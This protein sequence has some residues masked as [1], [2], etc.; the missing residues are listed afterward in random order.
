LTKDVVKQGY[1]EAQDSLKQKQI[2]EVKRIVLKTLEKIESLK[3]ER[4]SANDR[5]K[6]ID[7][8]IKLLKLDIDDLKEGRLDLMEERQA[9]DAKAKDTSLVIIVKETKVEH[10]YPY[11]Y[12]PWRVIWRGEQYPQIYCGGTSTTTSNSCDW[13]YLTCSSAKWGTPGTYTLSS[14]NTTNL[15]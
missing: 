1:N 11:W 7:E 9:K 12:W 15:R 6:D 10:D 2:D 14:G 4:D 8:R 3:T 5:V 13:T